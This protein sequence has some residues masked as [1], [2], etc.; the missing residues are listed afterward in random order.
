MAGAFALLACLCASPGPTDAQ[1]SE[2][3]IVPV[4]AVTPDGKPMI[5]LLP[6]NVRVHG[7]DVQVNGFSLDNGPRRI[8]LLIDISSSMRMSNGKVNLLQAAEHTAGLFLDR[9]SSVDSISVHA[10]AGKDREVVPF[11]QNLG[12]I[13]AAIMS[14]PKPGA[15]ET[16]REYGARTDLGNALSSILTVLSERPQFGDAIVIFSD[17]LF[18]RSGEGDI[19]NYY[20]Q[21]DY[22]YRVT[23][24]LGT[25]GVRVFFS[26]AGTIKGAPPLH[27]IELFIRAT[28][29]ESFELDDSGSAFYGGIN[30][31]DSY[32]RP[33]APIY[34]S[35]S[36]E[37]RVLALSA[38]I[39]DTY[40]LQLQ[41]AKPLVKPTRLSL[42]LVDQRGKAFHDVAVLRPAFIY[43]E[44]KTQP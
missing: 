5:N 25:L 43:P 9:V 6:Q 17:G 33:R 7:H 15:E 21:P 35:D 32:D 4:T 38:A 40:R 13:R 31:H 8:V 29:G 28:G 24:Q 19:L 34:R 1:H 11:T 14:L 37:Q 20:D 36:L 2:T 22:L 12:A 23:T 44:A 41:F 26:L 30:P 3:R 10:F 42:D 18:P 16:T 27:G 39:Q